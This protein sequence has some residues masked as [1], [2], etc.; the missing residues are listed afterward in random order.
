LQQRISAYL[1]STKRFNSNLKVAYVYTYIYIYNYFIL[2]C[3]G[4]GQELFNPR[5]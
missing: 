5:T 2:R 3:P 1:S 4:E